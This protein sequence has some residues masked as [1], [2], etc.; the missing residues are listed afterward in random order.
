MATNSTSGS[1]GNNPKS[2]YEAYVDHLS[3]TVRGLNA[4]G[5]Q[6]E[7]D[8]QEMEERVVPEAK[9]CL[10]D[11]KEDEGNIQDI[12][13][14]LDNVRSDINRILKAEKG[15]LSEDTETKSF[16][17]IE[18][19][20]K[21]IN[22]DVDLLQGNIVEE[23]N[24]MDDELHELGAMA[25]EFI[26]AY[27]RIAEFKDTHKWNQLKVME[28][29]MRQYAQRENRQDLLQIMSQTP[30]EKSAEEWV[31]HI[32]D[33]EGQ[34][35]SVLEETL[36]IIENDLDM[37]RQEDSQM[38]TEV[39]L[40]EQ[41]ESTLLQMVD[42]LNNSSKMKTVNDIIGKLQSIENKLSKEHEEEVV[43]REAGTKV[44]RLE[45]KLEQLGH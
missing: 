26:V 16:E 17:D 30:S 14:R 3:K 19:Q 27:R 1:A 15:E 20:L 41:L 29:S 11:A 8:I 9:Q 2:I 28:R 42:H 38:E 36:A 12:K 35:K 25:S 7:E 37:D 23:E 18:E 33:L 43:I 39:K 32:E 5:H 22:A 6:L 45:Q 44:M 31:N 40:I 24:L 21:Q 10:R 34:L 13:S 4:A